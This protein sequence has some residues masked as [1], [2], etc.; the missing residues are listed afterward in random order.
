MAGSHQV[1]LRVLSSTA[2]ISHCLRLGR[3]RMHLGQQP[4]LEKLGKLARISGVRLDPLSRFAGDQ[5]RGDDLAVDP[6]RQ[7][8]SLELVATRPRLIGAADRSRRLA[9]HPPHEAA[10]RPRFVRDGSSLRLLPTGPA[11]RDRNAPLV[12]VQANVGGTLLH[13]RLLRMRLCRYCGNPRVL[14]TPVL[15]HGCERSRSLHTV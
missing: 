8:L 2:E 7:E 10:H 4:S 11:N 9:L 1:L 15:P 3:R 13:D 14:F 6:L 5:R 12:H